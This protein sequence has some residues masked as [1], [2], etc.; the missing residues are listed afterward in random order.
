VNVSHGTENAVRME[1]LVEIEL[2]RSLGF[3]I[4]AVN[5]RTAGNVAAASR[6][7]LSAYRAHQEALHLFRVLRHFIC[8]TAARRLAIR[9]KTTGKD[10]TQFPSVA[11]RRLE[12]LQKR[13]EQ[14]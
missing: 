13:T 14:L 6:Q 12:T 1:E 9:I 5:D 2:S 10:L 11:T 8:R 7:E 3:L 4:V